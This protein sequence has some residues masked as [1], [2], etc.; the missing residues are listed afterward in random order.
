M[1]GLLQLRRLLVDLGPSDRLAY[2]D[3]QIAREPARRAALT[4]EALRYD[5]F[6]ASDDDVGAAE[7]AMRRLEDRPRPSQNSS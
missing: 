2:V 7:E 1:L 6:G 5:V 4:T 3:E